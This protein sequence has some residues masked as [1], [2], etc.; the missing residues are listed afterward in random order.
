M[1]VAGVHSFPHEQM[2]II[3]AINIHMKALNVISEERHTDVWQL[4]KVPVV[5][6]TPLMTLAR[7]LDTVGSKGIRSR[8]KAKRVPM[9]IEWGT[10]SF[11][12]EDIVDINVKECVRLNRLVRL[13]QRYSRLSKELNS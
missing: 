7:S 12:K 3:P 9:R 11:G 2:T 8:R 13:V 10:F 5:K 1:L 6:P 4:I